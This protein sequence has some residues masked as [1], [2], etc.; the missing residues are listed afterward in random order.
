MKR[1][2]SVIVLFLVLFMIPALD[3]RQTE[4]QQL[5]LNGSVVELATGRGIPSLSVWLIP[6]RDLNQPRRMTSTNRDGQFRFGNLAGGRYMLEV[7]QGAMTLHREIMSLE[8]DMEKRI[9]LRRKQ[10]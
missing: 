6:S 5:A 8:S 1:Y 3:P 4:A 10:E 7:H 9:T 2:R